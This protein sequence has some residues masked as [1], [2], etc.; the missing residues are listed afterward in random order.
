MNKTTKFSELAQRGMSII[1]TK[2][3]REEERVVF[4]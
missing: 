1:A 2:T 4:G 3:M